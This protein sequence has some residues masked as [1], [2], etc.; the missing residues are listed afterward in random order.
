MDGDFEATPASG[1]MDAAGAF[2]FAL[3]LA[4]VAVLFWALYHLESDWPERVMRDR[5]FREN[6]AAMVF[7]VAL[8]FLA[9]QLFV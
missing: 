9:V 7:G 4:V 3:G 5:A 2:E 8:A 1:V 6:A